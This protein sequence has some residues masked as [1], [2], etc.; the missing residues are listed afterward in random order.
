MVKLLTVVS[1]ISTVKKRNEEL[2]TKPH[3][4]NKSRQSSFRV[5]SCGFVDRLALS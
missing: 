1:S 5:A 4:E 3:E 2:S